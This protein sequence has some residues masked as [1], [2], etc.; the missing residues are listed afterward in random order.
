MFSAPKS[1]W[2]QLQVE[3]D[4][5]FSG[6]LDNVQDGRNSLAYEFAAKPGTSVQSPNFCQSHMLHGTLTIRRAIHHFVMERDEVS[7][8]RQLKIRLD[9][10]HP[11]SHGAAKRC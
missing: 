6:K 9:E 5:M 2:F 11:Q 1:T 7:V 8:T 3:H 10:C 4:I